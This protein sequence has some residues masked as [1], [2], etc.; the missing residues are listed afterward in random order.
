MRSP[1]LHVVPDQD[2]RD[3][4]Q[5]SPA[6]EAELST[7]T[8]ALIAALRTYTATVTGLRGSSRDVLVVF[9]ANEAVRG[10][11]IAWDVAADTHTGSFPLA[12][13]EFDDDDDDDH[14]TAEEA[15]TE[16][17]YAMSVVS[18]WDL[19]VTDAPALIEAG[20][21]AHQRLT[22]ADSDEDAKV[23]IQDDDIGPAIYALVHE[24]GEPW[25][26]LPGVEVLA[27]HRT[28]IDTEDDQPMTTA[29]PDDDFPEGAPTLVPDGE[30][31]FSESW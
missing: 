31:L 29:A 22:P 27:G 4:D 11:A 3:I 2:E 7:A 18:R 25:L 12:I 26:D 28:Y 14:D 20:R 23:A 13:Q 21:K 6:T 9:D 15:D 8:D 1:R 16:L 24:Y 19:E 30:V 5:F 17:V 10:A